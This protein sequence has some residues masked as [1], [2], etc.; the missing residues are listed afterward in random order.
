[1]HSKHLSHLLN[2]TLLVWLAIIGSRPALC[3]PDSIKQAISPNPF[4]VEYKVQFYSIP[5]PVP[6]NADIAKSIKKL[7]KELAAKGYSI[8]D[9]EI[10]AKQAEATMKVSTGGMQEVKHC[11]GA[12]NKSILYAYQHGKKVPNRTIIKPDRLF[13]WSAVRMDKNRSIPI[14]KISSIDSANPPK[15]ADQEE[16]SVIFGF[17]P[18]KDVLKKEPKVSRHPNGDTAI[19]FET[20]ASEHRAKRHYTVLLDQEGRI[21]SYLTEV[22]TG[23]N[24]GK[25]IWTASDYVQANEGWVPKA[26][27]RR[28]TRGNTLYHSLECKLVKLET[29]KLVLDE[30]FSDKVNEPT[31]VEDSRYYDVTVKYFTRD[32]LLTDKEVERR[33]KALAGQAQPF[34]FT[35]SIWR[36]AGIGL[37]LLGAIVLIWR[38]GWPKKASSPD[39]RQKETK[40]E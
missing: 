28:L 26:I 32:K 13:S 6:S 4:Y 24:A 12:G 37:I 20:P 5:E 15:K 38:F 33:A 9:I 23:T 17:Q 21:K 10:L 16:E 29:G 22:G 19:E 11:F 2:I 30:W 39:N 7:R 25:S 35:G 27:T 31:F 14:L 1:M 3:S 8:E 18:L 34:R 36:T 40:Q